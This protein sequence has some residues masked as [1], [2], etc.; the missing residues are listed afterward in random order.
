MRPM[1]K[2]ILQLQHEVFKT[3][4][5]CQQRCPELSFKSWDKAHGCSSSWVLWAWTHLHVI[6]PQ[7]FQIMIK[8]HNCPS[9]SHNHDDFLPPFSPFVNTLHL[10]GGYSYWP[11]PSPNPNILWKKW[12]FC[13][14]TC[15]LKALIC[16]CPT[17]LQHLGKRF[18]QK[19]VSNFSTANHLAVVKSSALLFGNNPWCT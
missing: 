11:P 1:G 10:P 6:F 2:L 16:T 8:A 19:K 18:I 13:Q 14:N 12:N 7:L 17:G 3:P 4:N 5:V 9:S 15:F